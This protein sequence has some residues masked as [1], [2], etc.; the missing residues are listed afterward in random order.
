[1]AD[2][3][4]EWVRN[5]VNEID[6][7]DEGALKDIF[8]LQV[9]QRSGKYA[10]L[11]TADTHS[12]KEEQMGEK[13]NEWVEN[14]VNDLD[15]N[16]PDYLEKLEMLRVTQR[17]DKYAKLIQPLM[18]Q[19]KERTL[20]EKMADYV[21]NLVDSL[22]PLLPTF[23]EDLSNLINFQ[24]SDVYQELCPELTKQYKQNQLIGILTKPLGPP[25]M[26]T[27]VYPEHGQ[28]DVP[29]DQSI[30][31]VFDQPMEPASLEMAIEV[32]P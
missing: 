15:P 24:L 25:P 31:I 30:M 27:G 4:N 16:D 11:T 8:D 6:P 5:R 14:R 1:M 19:W 21:S 18:H 7:E 2:K 20:K 12:Y 26:V 3:F 22:N 28:A 23:W 13:F 9:I 32:L 29:L 10:E 17:S